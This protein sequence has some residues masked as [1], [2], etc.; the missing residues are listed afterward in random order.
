MNADG[1][2]NQYCPQ[3]FMP[4]PMAS[5]GSHIFSNM[6]M[7]P[8]QTAPT[9]AGRQTT[10]PMAEQEG[11]QQ[12]QQDQGCTQNETGQEPEIPVREDTSSEVGKPLIIETSVSDALDDSTRN[13]TSCPTASSVSSSRS[14]SPPKSLA[15]SNEAKVHVGECVSNEPGSS[16]ATKEEIIDDEL[17]KE[18]ISLEPQPGDVVDD[19]PTNEESKRVSLSEGEQ[20]QQ[21]VDND[22]VRSEHKGT[23]S[24]QH[25]K[26]A[27]SN[28]VV[29]TENDETPA[30]NGVSEVQT[31][32]PSDGNKATNE[33]A[34]DTKSKISI[35][36]FSIETTTKPDS[37]VSPPSNLPNP[38]QQLF[39]S[40]AT[41]SPETVLKDDDPETVDTTRAA[42]ASG[43]EKSNDQTPSSA[44]GKETQVEK[45]EETKPDSGGPKS[46]GKEADKKEGSESSRHLSQTTEA[47]AS[48]LLGLSRS[49]V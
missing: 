28:D 18:E 20:Q 19:E 4:M 33:P 7:P 40:P 36:V 6:M 11:Q 25:A 2:F 30:A 14:S 17:P 29:R 16:P 32:S 39:P 13:S 47:L 23:A 22:A 34:N 48:T 1:T 45:T 49:S 42:T 31:S 15:P 43:E 24:L 8:P 3:Q 9:H 41:P 44:Q 46:D 12:Q 35:P 26:Q 38:E 5:M 27:A 37:P 10:A 21:P